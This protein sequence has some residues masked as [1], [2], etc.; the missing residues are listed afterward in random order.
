VTSLYHSVNFSIIWRYDDPLNAIIRNELHNQI[1]ILRASI[2]NE[3]SENP[4]SADN[5]FPQELCYYFRYDRPQYS[6]FHLTKKVIPGND[7]KMFSIA[8]RHVNNIQSNFCP[9]TAKYYREQWL[10][11]T[12]FFSP[13]TNFAGFNI[14]FDIPGHSIPP[15]AIRNPSVCA[16]YAS[17][18]TLIM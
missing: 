2:N 16:L 17:I 13:L 14:D 9:K 4:V 15:I 6:C 10:L 3:S 1:L 8:G 5:I 18:S 11:E 12:R 7:K